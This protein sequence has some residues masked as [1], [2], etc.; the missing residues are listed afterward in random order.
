MYTVKFSDGRE[1]SGLGRN[2]TML[3]SSEALEVP[4]GRGRVVVSYS[5]SE[6]EPE[7]KLSGEYAPGVV[8]KVI[9]VG[10]EWMFN[11]SAVSAEE[12]AR[13]RDRADL[14]YVAMMSGVEL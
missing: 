4:A 10:G 6:A 8:S 5:G 3:T 2:G 14:E 7:P 11:V 13:L 12:A 1:V 9:H